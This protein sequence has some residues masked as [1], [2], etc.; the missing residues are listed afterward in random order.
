MSKKKNNE[1]TNLVLH[2]EAMVFQS[3]IPKNVKRIDPSNNDHHIIADS[4]TTGNHHVIDC[5]D[6]VELFQSDDGTTYMKNTKPTKV[7]CVMADRHTAYEF[8][9]GTWE[10][11]IQKE[12]DHFAQ[13]LINVRD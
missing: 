2:G 7:R 3:K 9:P 4:E 13:N 11:G 10:F 5:I 8:S 1:L 12:Y 6:G